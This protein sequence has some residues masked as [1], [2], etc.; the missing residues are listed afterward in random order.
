[1]WKYTDDAAAIRDVLRLSRGMTFKAAVANLN[2]GGVKAVIIG[3]SRAHKTPELML[4]FARAVD[5]LNGKYI[6][7]EDV[8]MSVKD[9]DLV[10]T[11][12]SHAVGGSNEGG[13]GDPSIMTAFGVFFKA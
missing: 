4:A 7:A 6:T 10:R 11:V 9:I 8:G 3:D 13:S 2:L 1:M 12:T 5:S